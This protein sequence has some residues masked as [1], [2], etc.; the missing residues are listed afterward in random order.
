MSLVRLFVTDYLTFMIC[1][2]IL[3]KIT[4]DRKMN[5]RVNPKLPIQLLCPQNEND[6][7]VEA[8]RTRLWL[9]VIRIRS[10]AIYSIAFELTLKVFHFPLSTAGT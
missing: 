5:I 6:P 1:Y 9:V 4:Q 7:G 2:V 3:H 8:S 10:Q